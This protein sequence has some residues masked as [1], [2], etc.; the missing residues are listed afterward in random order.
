VA[1]L[2]PEALRGALAAEIER[3]SRVARGVSW[4]A[5][6]NLHLTLKFLGG[7][8]PDHLEA[9]ATTL[10]TVAAEDTAFDLALQG[11][12]A[13]PTP[14]RLRV[15]WAGAS[16][17]AV[18]VAGL[19]TRV[20]AALAPLG[21]APEGRPFSAHITLGRVRQPRRDPVLAAAIAAGAA[22]EFGGFRVD[23]LALMRSDL[24]PRGARYTL[25][26]S[27]LLGLDSRA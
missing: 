24:S 13:F 23:R 19:A 6:E 21:F 2:L 26:G 11:L 9:V 14:T 25:L 4:V 22:R 15:I 8:E 27:W 5:T 18:E 12:G 17:G 7:V 16:S 3:L 20:E 1:I 10:G